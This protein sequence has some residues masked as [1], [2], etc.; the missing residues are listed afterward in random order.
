MKFD[1]N[2]LKELRSS[3]KLSKEE[4]EKFQGL[5]QEKTPGNRTSINSGSEEDEMEETIESTPY[6]ITIFRKRTYEIFMNLLNLVSIML[7]ILENEKYNNYFI[8]SL[9]LTISIVYTIEYLIFFSYLGC[10]KM[11]G[12]PFRNIFLL[13]NIYIIVTH[14][15]ILLNNFD[16]NFITLVVKLG[17]LMRFLRI[18][19]LLDCFDD[20]KLLFETIKNMR[21][22]FL[23]LM[24][25][26]WSFFFLF[27]TITMLI[28]GGKI[29]RSQ[30][31]KSERNKLFTKKYQTTIIML[32]SMIMDTPS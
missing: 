32:I 27:S 10:K 3:F 23:S 20:F 24:A 22:S 17:I 5:L 18:K 2:Q 14:S 31:D 1:K 28:V 9:Q 8:I 29:E 7:I 13:I 11:I 30:F 21:F 15:L 4:C 19:F 6:F 26:L 16:E 12:F 25:T